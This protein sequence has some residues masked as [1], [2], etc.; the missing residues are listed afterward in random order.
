MTGLTF[1]PAGLFDRL[2]RLGQLDLSNNDL[3]SL[4]PRLFEKLTAL[5]RLV[6]GS[7]PGSARFLPLAKAGPGDGLDA[8]PGTEVTLGVAGAEN[9]LDDP[10]GDNVTYSWTQP[11]GEE[12]DAL[13]RE[14]RRGARP[15]RR[16]LRRTARP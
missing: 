12:V 2:T 16:R 8:A 1:L 7:N 5:T 10:W 11:G 14:Y 3:A 13:E 6:L 9:G 15:S 4:P